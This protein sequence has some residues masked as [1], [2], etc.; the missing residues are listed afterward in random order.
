MIHLVAP[1]CDWICIPLNLPVDYIKNRRRGIRSK[2]VEE[3]CSPDK[4]LI[5]CDVLATGGES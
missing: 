4:I 1:V 3:R 5:I 2:E